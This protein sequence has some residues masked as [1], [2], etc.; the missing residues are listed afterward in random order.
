M[1]RERN[2]AQKYSKNTMFFDLQR[3]ENKKKERNKQ[4]N[5]ECIKL[6]REIEIFRRKNAIN[7]YWCKIVKEKSRKEF[8]KKKEQNVQFETSTF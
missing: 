2:Y 5:V 7:Y 6:I 8:V 4:I 3:A 1:Y